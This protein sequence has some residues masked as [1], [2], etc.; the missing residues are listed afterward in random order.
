M[1]ERTDQFFNYLLPLPAWLYI[2]NMKS[3]PKPSFITTTNNKPRFHYH[4]NHQQPHKKSKRMYKKSTTKSHIA[5]DE[6]E[7][8]RRAKKKET[9]AKKWRSDPKQWNDCEVQ[10][11]V[12]GEASNLEVHVSHNPTWAQSDVV[13]WIPCSPLQREDLVLLS[14]WCHTKN[15]KEKQNEG[16]GLI[17]DPNHKLGLESLN[18]RPKSRN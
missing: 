9:K 3:T 10:A 17:G 2:K 16:F 7:E 12:A 6:E 15:P 4:Q 18:W 13:S 8:Q 5:E 11:D 1:V 14:L